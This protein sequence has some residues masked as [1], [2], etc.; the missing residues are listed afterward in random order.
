MKKVDE[1]RLFELISD[2]IRKVTSI[3]SEFVDTKYAP[4]SGLICQS[5]L[6]GL[7]AL[8]ALICQ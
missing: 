6:Y 3:E 4:Y 7:S 5:V 2:A 8:R 1:D